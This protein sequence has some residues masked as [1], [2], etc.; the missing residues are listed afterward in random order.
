LPRSFE[1]ARNILR[2]MDEHHRTDTPLAQITPRSSIDTCR[3]S[4]GVQRRSDRDDAVDL[5]L[6]AFQNAVRRIRWMAM[7][8]VHWGGHT[9]LLLNGRTAPLES[10]CRPR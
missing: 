3:I 7:R 4:K 6:V 1:L 8:G 9:S 5:A 10:R 2:A